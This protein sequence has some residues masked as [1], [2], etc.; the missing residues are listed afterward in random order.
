[1]KH[2]VS[3]IARVFVLNTVKAINRWLN[4][5]WNIQDGCHIDRSLRSL[6]LTLANYATFLVQYEGRSAQRCRNA[7]YSTRH[8]YFRQW[9]CFEWAWRLPKLACENKLLT[10]PVRVPMFCFWQP[11]TFPCRHRSGC[12]QRVWR[13]FLLVE[14]VT[15]LYWF[16][17]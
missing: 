17:M 4:F 2:S 5:R 11:W 13:N 6:I 8:N 15:Y 16:I 9:H 10:T 3:S 12:K 1:M 14:I 7:Q